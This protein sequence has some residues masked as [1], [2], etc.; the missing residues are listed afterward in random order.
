M[1]IR[2]VLVAV[3]SLLLVGTV[4]LA[5]VGA[6]AEQPARPYSAQEV[7]STTSMEF[8]PGFPL[9]RSTFGGRCTVPSDWVISFAGTGYATHVGAYTVTA[10]HC[11]QLGQTI[12][13]TGV[14][15]GRET[16]VA[17]NGDVLTY[18]YGDAVFWLADPGTVCNSMQVVFTGGTGRFTHA[19]GTG[20]VEG[21]FPLAGG[22][23][24]ADLHLTLHGTIDYDAADR[25]Q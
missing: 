1:N 15:D 19:S 10:S 20:E 9:E 3:P 23:A 25:A 7:V 13:T 8:A 5:P 4:A 6:A 14:S 2:R 18:T 17:A 12:E 24:V 11:T 16:V 22:P 21:C